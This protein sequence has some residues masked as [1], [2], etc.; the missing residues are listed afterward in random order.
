LAVFP[1]GSNPIPREKTDFCSLA[2]AIFCG[3]ASSVLSEN[4]YGVSPTVNSSCNVRPL[5]VF[6]FIVIE[7]VRYRD[8]GRV[9][10]G[11]DTKIDHGHNGRV[12]L[13]NLLIFIA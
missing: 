3:G 9:A 13:N 10:M 1:W 8:G 5:I 4:D 6:M 2:G 11:K 12:V 7:D